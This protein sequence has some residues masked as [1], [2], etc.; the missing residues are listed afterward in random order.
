MNQGIFAFLG[1]HWNYKKRYKHLWTKE[2]VYILSFLYGWFTYASKDWTLFQV[3]NETKFYTRY[4][5][6]IVPESLFLA[7]MLYC[8]WKPKMQLSDEFNEFLNEAKRFRKRTNMPQKYFFFC[9]CGVSLLKCFSAHLPSWSIF[10]ELLSCNASQDSNDKERQCPP[11]ACCRFSLDLNYPR[12]CQSTTSRNVS[13]I[14]L[15]ANSL[16]IG[17]LKV[18]ERKHEEHWYPPKG[19]SAKKTSKNHR[20]S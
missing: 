3:E 6:Y 8:Q 9:H 17:Q 10:F 16:K 5:P 18:T 1:K 7:N 15:T 13:F 12:N 4:G 14:S 20:K 11:T 19:V 2:S